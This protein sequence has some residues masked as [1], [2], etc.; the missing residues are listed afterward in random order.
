MLIKKHASVR[1][2]MREFLHNQKTGKFFLNY[3]SKLRPKKKKSNRF[4]FIKV[5]IMLHWKYHKKVRID[6]KMEKYLQLISQRVNSL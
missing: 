6:D 3:D 2:N 4:H 5:R 1:N